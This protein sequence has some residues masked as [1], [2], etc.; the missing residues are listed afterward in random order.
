MIFAPHCSADGGGC[1]GVL[2]GYLDLEIQRE[3]SGSYPPACEHSV[4]Q[5]NSRFIAL[6]N[7]LAQVLIPS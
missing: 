3:L 4:H 2:M 5:N 1:N 7:C 6:Y